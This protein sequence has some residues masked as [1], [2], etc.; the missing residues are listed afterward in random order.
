MFLTIDEFLSCPQGLLE[1]NG[2]SF[3][4]VHVHIHSVSV[5]YLDVTVVVDRWAGQ[6]YHHTLQDME[7]LIS[8]YVHIHRVGVSYLA[9]T[10][11][12]EHWVSPH[13]PGYGTSH[14]VL[15]SIAC[16]SRTLIRYIN[17]FCDKVEWFVR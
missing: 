2:Q 4:S 10:V 7:H 12:V 5:S 9:V 1:H 3:H 14:L 17:G 15:N 13:T 6:L 16:M 11:V 8:V